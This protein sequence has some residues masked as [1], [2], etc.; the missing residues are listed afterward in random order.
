M[1]GILRNKNLTTRFEILV[2]VASSGPNVQQR[3]IARK[4]GISPQA[5]SDYIAQ[6]AQ[7]GMLIYEGRS[8]YK[9]T[10]QGV[11]WIIKGL[12]ELSSYTTYV[13]KSI[14][15]ISVC[16]AI[17]ECDLT[18]GQRVGLRMKDGLL[19]AT[20]ELGEGASGV[21]VSSASRGE[22]VGVTRI[23]GIVPLQVGQVTILRV[24][25]IQRG[26]SRKVDLSRLRRE[27]TGRRFIACVGIESLAALRK[28][29]AEFHMYGAVEAAAEAA[30]TGLNPLVVCVEDEVSSLVKK[31][32]DENISYQLSDLEKS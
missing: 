23:E 11:N 4:L 20:D 1:T 19:F 16:A 28:I 12:R 30:K 22:D 18:E 13:E 15:N 31:L 6:L 8:S 7:E 21:T 24:P 14:S 25:H 29:G 2:E 32:E 26:G 17:A 9:V 10:N 5:V 3:D 27:V